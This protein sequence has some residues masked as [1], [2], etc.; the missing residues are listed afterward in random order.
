MAD[1]PPTLAYQ[2]AEGVPDTWTNIRIHRPRPEGRDPAAWAR[3]KLAATLEFGVM[4]P[5]V[6]AEVIPGTLLRLTLF[7]GVLVIHSFVMCFLIYAF[8]RGW[9]GRTLV[10]ADQ[11]LL[12]RRSRRKTIKFTWADI[13]KARE[14]DLALLITGRWR[15]V[16]VSPW[17][18]DYDSIRERTAAHVPVRREE[19][20]HWRVAWTFSLLAWGTFPLLWAAHEP[21]R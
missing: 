18:S 8:W 9:N 2:P 11:G 10:V 21:G 19:S 7:I 1:T 13:R 14:S 16:S 12:W 5:V 6:I 4:L 3:G 17:M 20:V 15:A